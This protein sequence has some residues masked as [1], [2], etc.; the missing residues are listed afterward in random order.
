V[1]G[2]RLGV[3]FGFGLGR[4]LRFLALDLGIFGGIP[5]L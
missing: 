3:G 5:R 2:L 4:L 1:V